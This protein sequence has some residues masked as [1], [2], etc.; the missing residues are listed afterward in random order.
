VRLEH[1]ETHCRLRLEGECGLASALD[2][3]N[4]L[5]EALASGEELWVDLEDVEEI[6]VTVLQLLWTAER[7]AEREKRKFQSR[8]PDALSRLAREAGFENFPGESRA[9]VQG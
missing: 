4:L 7:A 1:T 3:K 6:D 9:A 5:R 2:L 8:V